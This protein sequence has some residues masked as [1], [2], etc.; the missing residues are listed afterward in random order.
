MNGVGNNPVNNQ[1]RVPV[2]KNLE[3]FPR[4]KSKLSPPAQQSFCSKLC[5]CLKLLLKR[6]D[7]KPVHVISSYTPYSSSMEKPHKVLSNFFI[8]EQKPFR[9]RQAKEPPYLYSHIPD[10]REKNSS[11]PEF[12]NSTIAQRRLE[13]ADSQPLE[14]KNIELEEHKSPQ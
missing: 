7:P 11:L 4:D 10:L 12:P 9:F 8:Q 14:M 13:K 6:K 1:P 2:K 3:I 5:A